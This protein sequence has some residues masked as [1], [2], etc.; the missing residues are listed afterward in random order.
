MC[1]CESDMS[2]QMDY[3]LKLGIQIVKLAKYNKTYWADG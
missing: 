1:R 3:Y 2:L